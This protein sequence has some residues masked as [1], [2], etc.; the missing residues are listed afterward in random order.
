[1][2]RAGD[3][4]VLMC[5]FIFDS[6]TQHGRICWPTTTIH[7]IRM[8]IVFFLSSRTGLSKVVCIRPIENNHFHHNRAFRRRRQRTA[9][10]NLIYKLNDGHYALCRQLNA[11]HIRIATPKNIKYFL[12]IVDIRIVNWWTYVRASH[13]KLIFT[14]VSH[15][16]IARTIA[17]R[18]PKSIRA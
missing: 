14:S 17:D 2:I 7:D 18:R 8:R 4:D 10:S 13:N 5:T 16:S 11:Y 1:M 12:Y 3:R 9:W 15:P 6:L